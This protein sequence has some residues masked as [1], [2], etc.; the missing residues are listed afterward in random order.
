MAAMIPSDNT[1][2]ATPGEARV[3]A[4]LR[5]VFKP[6]Q[7]G[8]VWYSPYIEG[9]EPDFM[10][11][12]PNLGLIVFEVKDWVV[13]QIKAADAHWITF[14]GG[15]ERKTNPLKQA[16]QYTFALM[17]L[18]RLRGREL[19]SADPFYQ[20]QLKVPIQA[21]LIFTN[22]LREEFRASGLKAVLPEGLIF[23]SDDLH[24]SSRFHLDHSG[25]LFRQTLSTMFPPPFPC[26]LDRR[27]R[28]TFPPL[29]L[30]Q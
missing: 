25:R 24:P 3:Y 1:L 29:S 5:D 6:D 10:L 17:K 23:F 16:R 13:S 7:E 14:A 11:F 26:A 30:R 8:L 27:D 4:F 28:E 2:F 19:L 15:G 9:R 21:G 22:I 12:D 18:F 20:G